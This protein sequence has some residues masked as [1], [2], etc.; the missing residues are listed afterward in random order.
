MTRLRSNFCVMLLSF[1]YSA[2]ACSR[3]AARMTF[4]KEEASMQTSTFPGPLVRVLP[5]TDPD[6]VTV[7]GRTTVTTHN[8]KTHPKMVEKTVTWE[9]CE[10]PCYNIAVVHQRQEA[11]EVVVCGSKSKETMCCEMTLSEEQ[12]WC[13]SA[14]GVRNINQN[15][16]DMV[17]KE[18]THSIL[19]ESPDGD[20]LFTT[21]SG[22]QEF[23]G[24]HK[25][26]NYK[27]GPDNHDKEQH[28]KGM[29]LSRRKGDPLQDKI[30]AFYN[31]KDAVTDATSKMWTPF[32]TQ[33]CLADKGGRK[34]E[35]QF[36]WTSQLSAR[37][38][39]GDKQ[40]RWTFFELVDIATIHAELWQD[41]KIYALFKNEWSVSA[42][43]VYSVSD[44]DKLFKVSKFR[45]ANQ[46][47]LKN[48]L[49]ECVRDSTALSS[50]QLSLIAQTIEMESWVMP[51]K[52]SG[53][54]FTNHHNYTSIYVDARTKDPVLFLTLH[55]GG[56][57][58][59]VPLESQGFVIAEYRPFTHGADIISI[60]PHP[61]SRRLYVGARGQL[62]VMDEA[63][64]RLYGDTCEQCV[65]ARDPQCGWDGKHCT[66]ETQNTTQEV[67]SGNYSV[68][69]AKAV[70][71]SFTQ[72]SSVQRNASLPAQSRYFLQCPMM[73]R[74]A[75]YS[76]SHRDNTMPCT[77]MEHQ[78]LHLITSMSKD[79]EGT[80]QC[81][82]EE[83]GYK[84]VVVEHQLWLSGGSPGWSPGLLPWVW[85]AFLFLSNV[86]G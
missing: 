19:V 51:V 50:Q 59:V 44:I 11:A 84:R 70:L 71:L 24:I 75:T 10:G 69:G 27:V 73:S 37:L 3:H 49:R 54:V 57:H 5:Q 20:T 23:V 81:V 6:I 29:M 31:E 74:H 56:L 63:T 82:S 33:V 39:C 18:D 47:G 38:F 2:V 78:C 72:H 36:I 52:N 62:A 86:A 68:C 14:E 45:A 77:V 9:G 21:Y 42:V 15:I 55:N 61:T 30:Y 58:K 48:R 32:V 83:K 64:C 8:F 85:L 13:R 76:W 17:M 22:Y 41:T 16:R 7:F 40:R 12:L 34:N 28:Y 67:T 60:T 66:S 65:L 25:F 43:C 1:C 79:Q 26:G 53:P 46:D 4:S 35:L 80:Y